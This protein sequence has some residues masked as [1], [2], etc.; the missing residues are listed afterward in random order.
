MPQ[1]PKNFNEVIKAADNESS[2]NKV[3]IRVCLPTLM[4]ALAPTHQT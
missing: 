3:Y 4:R 1:D 2:E